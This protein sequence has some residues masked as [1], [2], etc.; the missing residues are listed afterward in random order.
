MKLIMVAIHDSK[1]EMFGRPLFVRAFG[2]AERSFSDVVNDGTSDY[3]KHPGDFTLF[4]VGFFDDA[5]GQVQPLPSP[6]SLGAGVTFKTTDSRQ[7]SLI[8]EG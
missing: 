5:S 7:L 8:K 1:S 6:V 4:H 2:E 3:A